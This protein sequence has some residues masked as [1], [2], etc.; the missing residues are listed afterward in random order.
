MIGD[1]LHPVPS[2]IPQYDQVHA[3]RSTLVAESGESLSTS[4]GLKTN[5]ASSA[6]PTGAAT[7]ANQSA[8]ITALQS[9]AGFNIPPY[10]EIVLTYVASGN[11]AGEIETV[12]YKLDS[13]TLTTL[14]LS[15]DGGNNLTGV[16][17]S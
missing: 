17:K 8:E 5:V 13:E 7:A 2:T 4:S 6:L 9:I 3:M 12:V 10:D 11:G 14:T 16:T 15:Y 1:A